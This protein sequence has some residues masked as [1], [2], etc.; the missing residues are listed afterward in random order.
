MKLPALSWRFGAMPRE[1]CGKVQT[2][3]KKRHEKK[4]NFIIISKFSRVDRMR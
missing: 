2:N 3:K 1:R 4:S